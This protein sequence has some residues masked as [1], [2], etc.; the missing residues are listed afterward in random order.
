MTIKDLAERTGYAVGTVSRALNGHP[1][2]SEKARQTILQAAKE[3]GFELN[4]NAKQLKQQHATSILVVVKGT[5]NEL[6]GELV[7]SVQTLMRSTRYPVYVDYLDEDA[8]EVTR[9]IQL[10]REKKP[11]GILFMGGNNCN[12]RDDFDKI[13]IPC[14]LLTNNASTL[15]FPNL[16]SVCVNDHQAC[17]CAMD[18]LIALGHR[19]I[20]VVGGC[21]DSSEISRLRYD[22]CLESLHSHNIAF[23][24]ELDYQGVRFSYDGGYQ[25]TA[26]LLAQGR[27][28]TALFA[29]CDVMAIGAIRALRDHGL[30]VPEDVSVMGYDGLPLGSY[31]VPKLSTISQPVQTLARRSVEILTACIEGA[32][33]R[34]ETVPFVL[35]QRESTRRVDD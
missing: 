1:N 35:C 19:R 3:C 9:A 23:D 18:S 28:F 22:G 6:F 32:P 14:L 34:H 26:Q 12:F 13:Q 24:E 5:S 29:E 4:I 10:C 8:N 20:V 17:R 16:S 21:L 31:M 15:D 11:L 30:R 33:S 2:V 25:A 7:E 27:R